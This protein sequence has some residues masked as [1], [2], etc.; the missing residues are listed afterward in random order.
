MGW[1]LLVFIIAVIAAW[2]YASDENIDYIRAAYVIPIIIIIIVFIYCIC[3]DSFNDFTF[4]LVFGCFPV[5]CLFGYAVEKKCG[6]SAQG[7]EK[8]GRKDSWHVKVAYTECLDRVYKGQD[9]YGHAVYHEVQDVYYHGR[10]DNCGHES[11]FVK[12]ETHDVTY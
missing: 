11:D 12:R 7:C 8:C 3:T 5:L 9:K 4:V 2:F 10:C 1:F 6:V